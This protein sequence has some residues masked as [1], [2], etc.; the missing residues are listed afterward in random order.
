MAIGD[1]A[2][3]PGAGGIV[4]FTATQAEYDEHGYDISSLNLLGYWY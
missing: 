3:D 2:S 4:E 1:A